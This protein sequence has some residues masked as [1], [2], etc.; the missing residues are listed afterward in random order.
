MIVVG[1]GHEFRHDDAAG[2]VAAR[3]LRERGVAAL[4]HE[5]DL[6]T[7]MDQW[8]GADG[9]VLVDAVW[10]GAA[11]GTVHRLDAGASP[12]PREL[13][14]SSTHALGLADAVELSR[15]LGTLPARV[16]VFGI[17]GRDFTAG[18]GLSA[19][20]EGALSSL[21]EEVASCMKSR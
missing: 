12:L 20:V 11:P 8:K 15:A 16:L 2:L 4:E 9:V 19:E 1:L 21:V 5:G 17:E 10:S 3:R 13:F 6:A 18:V 7:L 14:K